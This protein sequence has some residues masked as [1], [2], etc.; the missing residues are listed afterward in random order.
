MFI[1]AKKKKNENQMSNKCAWMSKVW[2]THIK[3]NII[4][5]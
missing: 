1:I 4:Q 5:S 2:Y 3:W